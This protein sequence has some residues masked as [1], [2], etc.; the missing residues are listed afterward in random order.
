MEFNNILPHFQI[1]TLEIGIFASKLNTQLPL[2]FT[3]RPDPHALK[4]NAF[5]TSWKNIKLLFSPDFS[6]SK[7]NKKD[8]IW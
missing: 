5:S 4:I 8:Y 3:Y 2:Y 7:S 1:F 6:S